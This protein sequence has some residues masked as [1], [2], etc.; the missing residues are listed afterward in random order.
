MKFTPTATNMYKVKHTCC[1]MFSSM[2]CLC[3]Y[4]FN[5]FVDNMFRIDDDVLEFETTFGVQKL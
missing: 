5:P 1:F 3:C 4:F 2:V